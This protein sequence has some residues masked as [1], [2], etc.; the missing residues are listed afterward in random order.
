MLITVSHRDAFK[1]LQ[2]KLLI[3]CQKGQ[4]KQQMFTFNDPTTTDEMVCTK[5]K[6]ELNVEPDGPFH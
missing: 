5:V 6:K 2:Q 1:C 3:Y 4:K